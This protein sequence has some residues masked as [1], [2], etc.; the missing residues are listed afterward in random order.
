MMDP[1]RL[2]FLAVVLAALFGTCGSVRAVD[3]VETPSA[4]TNPGTS[5]F[6]VAEAK[7]PGRKSASGTTRHKKPKAQ[8]AK[9]GGLPGFFSSVRDAVCG[10]CVN[11]KNFAE[12]IWPGKPAKKPATKAKPGRQPTKRKTP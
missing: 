11:V 8:A 10:F 9:P 4:G 3:V 2:F 6:D 7:A 12:S 5:V 1:A